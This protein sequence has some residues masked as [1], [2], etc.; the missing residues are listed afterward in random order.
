MVVLDIA[1]AKKCKICLQDY[2]YKRDV[3]NRLFMAGLSSFEL[4]MLEEILHSSLQFPLQRLVQA[5]DQPLETVRAA[6]EKFSTTGLLRLTSDQ[7]VVDKELRKYFEGLMLPFEEDFVP[8]MDYIQ[9]LL[10]KVPIGV[11]PTWYAI[12]RTANNIFE[13]LVERI[14]A[15]PQLV[16]RYLNEV[17]HTDPD[18]RAIQNAVFSHPE[19]TVPSAA[20]RD[21][22]GLSREAFEECMLQLE[23]QFLCCHTYRQV[24][25]RWEQVVTPFQEWMDYL[26]HLQ[27][28]APR[29]LAAGQVQALYASEYPVIERMGELL[30][31]AFKAPVPMSMA[32]NPVASPQSHLDASSVRL[33]PLLGLGELRDGHLVAAPV[34]ES[35]CSLTLE[36]RAMGLYRHPD[37]RP[38][39]LEQV[40]ERFLRDAERSMAR[41]LNM[42]WVDLDQFIQGMV[43]PL[44]TEDVVQLQRRNRAWRYALPNYTPEECGML[45]SMIQ[46]WLFESGVVVLGTFQN[47]PCFR[48]T[49]LGHS[50]YS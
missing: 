2:D 16:Q 3:E 38:R 43:V 50:L 27:R 40:Q 9:I 19:L 18:L 37:H 14:L 41:A 23:F 17:V 33:F 11:L 39:G 48:L 30:T 26:I 7:V 25:G 32:L 46:E 1:G 49:A 28:T 31:Q 24:D 8:G 44:R 42:G 5:L 45:R 34:A 35:W 21:Q 22:L 47:R 36:D 15:T 4:V 20:L 29:S 6:L 12:P 13:S 10:R